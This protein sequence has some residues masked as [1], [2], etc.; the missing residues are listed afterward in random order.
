MAR[1]L[2]KTKTVLPF[3]VSSLNALKHDI[4][5]NWNIYLIV[6]HG[7][8]ITSNELSTVPENTYIIFRA[9]T[10][11]SIAYNDLISVQNA[12]QNTNKLAANLFSKNKSRKNKY[13]F[14]S[15]HNNNSLKNTI[16]KNIYPVSLIS[17]DPLE[18]HNNN[19]NIEEY[20]LY[21]TIY[22]PYMK[23]IPMEI[24]FNKRYSHD[25]YGIYKLP[26]KKRINNDT[27]YSECLFRDFIAGKT[28]KL[29]SIINRI[30]EYDTKQK[31]IIV[32][33]CRLLGYNYNNSNIVK[34]RSYSLGHIPEENITTFV[35]SKYNEKINRE[36]NIIIMTIY[37]NVMSMVNGID[38]V[39]MHLLSVSNNVLKTLTK[40]DIDRMIY[41]K[42]SDY[43]ATIKMYMAKYPVLYDKVIHELY[44]H[45]RKSYD[46]FMEYI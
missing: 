24:E 22:H 13:K 32:N 34:L 31:L 42:I 28:F 21:N 38:S 30:N 16:G 7:E 20:Q 36:N 4:S 15:L 12:L 23:Y 43:I 10:G 27:I 14:F 33:S 8:I 40:A 44:M 46:L 5:T 41:N 25:V 2:E 6:G 39:K 3:N 9:S 26:L 29:D 1:R 11:V 37:D 35:K 19:N 18:R 45:N 17:K